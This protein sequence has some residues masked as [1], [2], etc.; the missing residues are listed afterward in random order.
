MVSGDRTRVSVLSNLFASLAN[1]RNFDSEIL[2]RMKNATPTNNESSTFIPEIIEELKSKSA[3]GVKYAVAKIIIKHHPE[4]IDEVVEV[5]ESLLQDSGW[6]G[7]R[8]FGDGSTLGDIDDE[9]DFVKFALKPKV[10]NLAFERLMDEGNPMT[11]LKILEYAKNSNVLKQIINFYKE[12]T[13][14]GYSEA[15]ELFNPAGYGASDVIDSDSYNLLQSLVSEETIKYK[16][17]N[18]APRRIGR[19]NETRF[20]ELYKILETIDADN[21]LKNFMEGPISQVAKIKI[22]RDILLQGEDT[23]KVRGQIAEMSAGT[24]TKGDKSWKRFY[25]KLTPRDFILSRSVGLSDEEINEQIREIKGSVNTELKQAYTKAKEQRIDISYGDVRTDYRQFLVNLLEDV[26]DFFQGERL[27][28]TSKPKYPI[29]TIL[30]LNPPLEV[31]NT[32]KFVDQSIGTVGMGK[33]ILEN[34]LFI[35]DRFNLDISGE[36]KNKFGKYNIGANQDDL[37]DI[38]DENIPFKK[39]EGDLEEFIDSKAT[40]IREV[41]INNIVDLLG[42]MT[43]S[44]KYHKPSNTAFREAGSDERFGPNEIDTRTGIDYLERIGLLQER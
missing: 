3:K 33:V 8:V 13:E 7:T 14:D 37:E 31:P 11:L 28:D 34:M 41:I 32:Y 9:L 42:K 19:L 16:A 38:L 1:R 5:L 24:Q 20:V 2:E 26:P 25:G 10:R 40:N 27:L 18:L 21:P 30:L 36:F 15:V 23:T 22:L 35:F 44:L 43:S 6:R 29:L 12:G 4:R 39:I 17:N